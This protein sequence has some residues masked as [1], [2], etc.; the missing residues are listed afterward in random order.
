[1]ELTPRQVEGFDAYWEGTSL[2][3]CPYDE[4]SQWGKWTEWRL[5]WMKG[6][7]EAEQ[8]VSA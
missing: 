8:A 5:G 1:M 4:D 7:V 2:E 6:Y 3:A